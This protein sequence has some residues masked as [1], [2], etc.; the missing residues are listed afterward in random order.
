MVES[1]EVTVGWLALE[2]QELSVFFHW[3]FTT[4]NKHKMSH[5]PLNIMLL[6]ERL[7]LSVEYDELMALAYSSGWERMKCKMENGGI[8]NLKFM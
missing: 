7:T 1:R 6:S 5:G 4:Q 2:H 8:V 3:C